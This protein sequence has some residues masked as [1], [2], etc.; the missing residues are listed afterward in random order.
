M[1]TNTLDDQRL[2]AAPSFEVIYLTGALHNL[3]TQQP[4]Q[5][6]HEF[7]ECSELL[8]HLGNGILG[9]ASCLDLSLDGFQLLGEHLLQ[10][11]ELLFQ[12]FLC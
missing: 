10:G 1:M 6:I 11:H 4:E 8:S 12:G 7:S 2:T 3:L 9:G 5:T